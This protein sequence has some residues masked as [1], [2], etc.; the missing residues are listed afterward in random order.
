MHSRPSLDSNTRC[1]NPSAHNMYNIWGRMPVPDR[2]C[3]TRSQNSTAGTPPP[4]RQYHTNCTSSS[5]ILG[6]DTYLKNKNFKTINCCYICPI[7][8]RASRGSPSGCV[9][10][11][12]SRSRTRLFCTDLFNSWGTLWQYGPWF[13]NRS[14]KPTCIIVMRIRCA[15]ATL[16]R[17]Y[18]RILRFGFGV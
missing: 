8:C 5:R 10:R 11:S 2:V 17:I 18:S 7:C 15:C 3:S 6:T 9:V 13:R 16:T 14:T 4:G 1:R 12:R